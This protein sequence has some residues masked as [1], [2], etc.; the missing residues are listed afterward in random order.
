MYTPEE[1]CKTSRMRGCSYPTTI[2]E[3]KC[4][5][6]CYRYERMSNAQGEHSCLSPFQ[7]GYRKKGIQK[8][9]S[10]CDRILCGKC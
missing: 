1:V 5:E 10:L 7:E 6:V 2:N 8:Y 4:R 9:S 3:Q